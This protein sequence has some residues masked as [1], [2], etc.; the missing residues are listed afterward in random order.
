MALVL[1]CKRVVYWKVGKWT[2]IGGVD[3]DLASG[4]HGQGDRIWDAL[5]DAV[6][7]SDLMSR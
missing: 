2:M 4:M 7:E 1:L 5:I 3:D 6:G